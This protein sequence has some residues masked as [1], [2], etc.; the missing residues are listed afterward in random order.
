MVTWNRGPLGALA[1]HP[2]DDVRVTVRE[3]DVVHILQ[4]EHQAYD[5]ILLDVDNGPR[6]L[7][8]KS[9]GWLYTRTG[10]DAAFTALRPA[11]V[12]ALWSAGPDRA[13]VQLLRKA[14]FAVDEERVRARGPRGGGYH[15]IWIAER[16]AC[17]ENV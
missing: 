10:L 16:V 7:T 3:V 17:S 1:G 9:N 12:F 14:G 4:A 8:R 5:A 13:F 6:G 11:G 2:L 15:T